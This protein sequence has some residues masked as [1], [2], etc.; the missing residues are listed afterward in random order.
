MSE[1]G[2]CIKNTPTHSARKI[3][4]TCLSSILCLCVRLSLCLRLWLSPSLPS[5]LDSISLASAGCM[6]VCEYTMQCLTSL[7]QKCRACV[8]RLPTTPLHHPL[9]QRPLPTLTTVFPLCVRASDG[10][11]GTTIWAAVPQQSPCVLCRYVLRV[12]LGLRF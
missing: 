11:C 7:L 8:R 6:C 10:L 9:L 3:S 4:L 5:L 1:K 12:A 2:S